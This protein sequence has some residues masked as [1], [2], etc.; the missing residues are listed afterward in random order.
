MGIALIDSQTGRILEVNPWFAQIVGRS[1][2]ELV[3]LDWMSISHPED[4]QATLDRTARL[5]AGLIDKFQQEKRYV[6]PDGTTVWVHMTLVPMRGDEVAHRH[7]AMI[8]DIT[9]KKHAEARQLLLQAQFEQAQKMESLGSLAGGVAHDMNNVLAAILGMAELGMDPEAGSDRVRKSFDTIVKASL[10][11]G[12]LVK[13]LLRFARQS[14]A[15]EAS[16]ILNLNDLLRE[17]VSLLERTTLAKVR[18]CL[19][20]ASDLRP[21]VGDSSALTHAIMNLCVN[22]VDANRENGTLT[23]RTRNLADA[24]TEIL[25]E[26]TGS[27]MTK[28]VLEKALEPF[29]TTKGVGK[30]TGLG[31]S[32]VYST[33]KAHGGL[34]EIQSE[35]NQGTRVW[36]RFPACD[37]TAQATEPGAEPRSDSP[38]ARLSV[39]LVDDDELSQGSVQATLE[40]MGHGVTL[41][42]SGEE[43]LA[44]LQAG[45]QPDVVILDMHMP[46][47]GGAGTLPRLRALCP[48]QPVLVITGR[49]D[50]AVLD[51][52]NAQPFVTLLSKPFRMKELQQYLETLGGN[53]E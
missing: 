28:E 34:L 53:D 43:A 51:L 37:V 46:G 48:T 22:A 4:V 26:D 42:S 52:V 2:P 47:L 10:R 5:R 3:T 45:Y 8:E 44:Q 36:M 32:M 33:V 23:L 25:V 20:L 50:Q 15:I 29:F 6:H 16:E 9:E 17:Q 41:A 38:Q 18:L 24:W 40:A 12:A 13:G 35:P 27:G 11:G 49:V 14:P 19:D 39:L 7:L 30:G 31:L 21:I 1:V